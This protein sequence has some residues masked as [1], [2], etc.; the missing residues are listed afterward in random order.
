VECSFRTRVDSESYLRTKNINYNLYDFSFQMLK[1][2]LHL[3]SSR[4]SSCRSN[5]RFAYLSLLDSINSPPLTWQWSVS[6]APSVYGPTNKVL[7]SPFSSTI[8]GGSGGTIGV[9]IKEKFRL[10]HSSNLPFRMFA[11]KVSTSL[12]Y[13]PGPLG[14]RDFHRSHNEMNH[15]TFS[16]REVKVFITETSI[17]LYS[18]L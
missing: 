17:E 15:K 9:K 11:N 14:A 3:T 13:F 6:V 1:S 18:W 12:N 16:K 2:S 7:S 10:E 8:T 4:F 5:F